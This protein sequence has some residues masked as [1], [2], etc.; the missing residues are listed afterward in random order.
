MK[1]EEEFVLRS[2][3]IYGGEEEKEPSLKSQKMRTNG[4]KDSV[5]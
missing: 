1:T 5:I 4:Y 3:T 2:L